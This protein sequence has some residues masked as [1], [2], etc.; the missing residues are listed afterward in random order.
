MS[1]IENPASKK[2]FRSLAVTIA[3][4][5]TTLI[6]AVLLLLAT[7]ELYFSFRAQESIV[8]THQ[9][10][11]A[12]DAANTVTGFL[13]EKFSILSQ[14]AD[15]NSLAESTDRRVLVMNALLERNA[16]FRQLFLLDLTGDELERVSRLT[17]LARSPLDL[18][19]ESLLR[20]VSKG[21]EY[22]SPV[23]IDDATSEPLILIAIPT[24]DLFQETQGAFVAEISL[25]FLWNLVSSIQLAE[26]GAAYVVDEKGTLIAYRDVSRVLRHEN[27]SQLPEVKEFLSSKKTPQDPAASYLDPVLTGA[28]IQ[29]ITV[30]STHAALL[31]P[32]WGVIV[33][34]PVSQAY[35]SLTE[36]LLYIFFALLFSITLAVISGVYIA[37]R[38]TRP[39]L[40]LATITRE[41]STGT[42]NTKIEIDSPN[43]IGQL[44]T[45]FNDM[46]FKLDQSYK[47]LREET[48]RLLASINS[49]SFGFIIADRGHRILLSNKAVT[50]VLNLKSEVVGSED[51]FGTFGK[52]FDIKT[53]AEQYM[54]DGKTGIKEIVFGKK[55]LR[56]IVAPISTGRDHEESIGYVVVL[57]DIT[58]RKALERGREEFFSIASHELRTP[59]TAIRGNASLLLDFYPG[60][61]SNE[62]ARQIITDIHAASVRLIGIVNDFLNVSRLEQGRLVFKKEPYSI[63]K[64]VT[65]TLQEMMS[66]AEKKNIGFIFDTS[67]RSYPLVFIDKDRVKE[68]LVNLI[69]NAI[70]YTTHGNIAI[71]VEKQAKALKVSIS[72]TGIGI[73]PQLQPLLF[74]KFQQAG[75]DQFARDVTQGTG[76]GLYISKLIV[77]ALGGTISL[78]ESTP[79]KG[80]TFSFTLPLAPGSP[81]GV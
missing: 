59:L 5:F 66:V 47:E 57:E 48:A 35:A 46:M 39:I 26:G 78:T 69:G 72:D 2:P 21:N 61:I 14:A 77:E 16:A 22:I 50:D 17:I 58:E 12:R 9:Q 30:L 27:L 13:N 37:R 65:E 4:S 54:K 19:R 8:V 28:G 44:T 34:T 68:V 52:E 3:I 45:A 49:L 42:L 73:P 25:K 75:K 10:L 62:K 56:I 24:H 63:E 76:L 32:D 70:N 38:I 15:L 1:E 64:I 51:P 74:R 31:F 36:Q 71:T 18:Y 41:M 67:V 53:E 60:K 80:S 11:I 81:E 40:Q 7:L 33:E 23:Y 55:F 29:G 43:E 20:E 79:G 6:V